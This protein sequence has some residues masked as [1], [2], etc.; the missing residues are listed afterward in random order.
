MAKGRWSAHAPH[1]DRPLRRRLH[2][3][4]R[5]KQAQPNAELVEKAVV[6]ADLLFSLKG[7][8]AVAF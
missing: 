5:D 2:L 7:R 4:R 8:A 1:R 6:L 3:L